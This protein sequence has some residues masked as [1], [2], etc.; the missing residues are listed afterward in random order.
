M[1]DDELDVLILGQQRCADPKTTRGR[2][3][4]EPSARLISRRSSTSPK[5]VSKLAYEPWLPKAA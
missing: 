2:Q 4:D 5:L 1:D 3:A